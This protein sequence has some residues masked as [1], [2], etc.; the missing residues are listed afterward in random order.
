MFFLLIDVEIYCAKNKL[1]T[2]VCIK[3]IFRWGSEFQKIENTQNT[4]SAD[5]K[6]YYIVALISSLHMKSFIKNKL[7]KINF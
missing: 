2:S 6:L 5:F 1:T 7:A 3:P 4:S